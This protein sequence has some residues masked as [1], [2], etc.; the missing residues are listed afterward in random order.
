MSLPAFVST[1]TQKAQTTAIAVFE[2]MLGQEN[3]TSILL[4]TSAKRLAATMDRF[5]FYL[6]TNE[7]K[8]VTTGFR[9]NV[10]RSQLDRLKGEDGCKTYRNWCDVHTS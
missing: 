6:A 5:G 3:V 2:R 10:A 8:K 1:N 9:S 4:D 7:D